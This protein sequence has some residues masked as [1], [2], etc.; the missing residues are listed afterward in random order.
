MADI[1]IKNL[2]KRFGKITA[3]ENLSL[4][5]KDK[6]FLVILG[7]SGCGKT[8]TLRCIAGLETPDEGEIYIG[9]ELVNDLS[10]ADRDIA[11]VF[12]N[13][14]LYP[15]MTAYDNIAYPLKMRKYSKHEI[16]K[17]VKEVARLLKIEHLLNKKPRQL[18]GGEQ[19]RVALGRAIVRQP[20]AFLMDEPLSNLDAKLRLYMRAELKRLQKELGIT[21]IYVTHDQAEAMTM[22]DRILIMNKGKL[23]Q[24]DE[25][26]IIYSKPANV[27]VASFIGS[28]PMNLIDVSIV[29]KA[30]NLVFETSDFIY[31]IPPTFIDIIK[32]N[33]PNDVIL[34]IRPEDIKISKTPYP[35]GIK[36]RVYV[37]E[38]LGMSSI[39]NILIGDILIKA[40]ADPDFKI[41]INETVYIRF[42]E[43]KLHIFDKKTGKIII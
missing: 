32:T 1:T 14:A 33:I 3:V 8:T 43:S 27:F 20:K 29:N 2:T 13:Y 39:I 4:H 15:H 7:P 10:P 31:P 18:S 9:G 19:Q 30:N 6:E 24:L 34:G 17:R 5:V 21:T 41:N 12:Q 22:A 28:P 26:E 23:Q 16:N 35:N 11:M 25:P 42:N 36:G 38:P 37:V 40:I